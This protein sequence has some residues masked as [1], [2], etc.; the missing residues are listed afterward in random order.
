MLQTVVL[1]GDGSC[2]FKRK[3]GVGRKD[4]M[5]SE[6]ASVDKQ[7]QAFRRES[8]EGRGHLT[9]KAEGGSGQGRARR[10]EDRAEL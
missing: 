1:L 6:H 4:G 7:S 9:A 8:L 2:H 10:D 5:R 3:L